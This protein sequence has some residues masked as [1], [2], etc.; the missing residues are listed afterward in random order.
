MA[1]DLKYFADAIRCDF[2]TEFIESWQK[3]SDFNSDAP[4]YDMLMDAYEGYE[5]Q[6]YIQSLSK[7]Q[8]IFYEGWSS[9]CWNA[10]Y[11]KPEYKGL[12]QIECLNKF[13][14]ERIPLIAKE[15]NLKVIECK[16]DFHE[17]WD[18]SIEDGYIMLITFEQQ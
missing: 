10:L 13:F 5:K 9:L 11:E 15:C 18:D 8:F 4:E 6:T 2:I 12:T 17:S 7:K 16:Y 1:T 3:D 14:A